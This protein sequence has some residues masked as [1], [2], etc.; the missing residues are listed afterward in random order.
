MNDFRSGLE[1]GRGPK[2]AGLLM[3]VKKPSGVSDDLNTV[4]VPRDARRT[5]NHR[6]E[7]RHRLPSE[8]AKLKVGRKNFTV[9]LVNLSGGGAMIQTDAPLAMWQKVTLMLGECDGL[10]CAVLWIKGDRVGLEF[11]PETQIAGDRAKRDDLLV[12]V[13]KRN[14]PDLKQVPRTPEPASAKVAVAQP[15]EQRRAIARHPLIWTGAVLFNHG[16]TP[17]RLRNISDSGALLDS[18]DCFPPNAEVLL[19]LGGAGQHF[20]TVC[21]SRGDQVGLK[22]AQ[23]FDVSLL[24]REKPNVSDHRWVAPDYLRHEDNNQSAW[25]GMSLHDLEGFLKR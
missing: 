18:P 7:D 20:A 11:A 16:T 14:F 24:A 19:D 2:K 5:A 21:W 12:D 15:A 1:K 3:P 9:D 6:D 25:R 10:D 17:V 23:P 4:S 22:F 13:L 8:Q